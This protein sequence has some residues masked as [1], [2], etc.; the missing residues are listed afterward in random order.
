MY[1]DI[2]TS[3][4]RW[5]GFSVWRLAMVPAA[6]ALLLG[7][8]AVGLAGPINDSVDC[9]ETACWV[10]MAVRCTTQRVALPRLILSWVASQRE[11]Y[12]RQHRVMD[13]LQDGPFELSAER[14]LPDGVPEWQGWMIPREDR[15]CVSGVFYVGVPVRGQGLS[16]LEAFPFVETLCIL[17]RRTRKDGSTYWPRFCGFDI[18]RENPAVTIPPFE[19]YVGPIERKDV[20]YVENLRCL[21][22]VRLIGVHWGDIE[23]VRLCNGASRSLEMLVLVNTDVTEKG[24]AGLAP[25]RKLDRLDIEDMEEGNGP[26]CASLEGLPPLPSLQQVCLNGPG[27]PGKALERLAACTN[28]RYLNLAGARRIRDD[29]LKALARLPHLESLDL[30]GTSVTAAGLRFLATLPSLDRITLGP[31]VWGGRAPWR[32]NG[33][34]S[35]GFGPSGG[36]Q[37]FSKVEEQPGPRGREK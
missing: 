24:L 19:K 21:K 17:D 10:S 9:A 1:C 25:L 34:Q 32:P 16:T 27:I 26:S 8:P 30:E 22:F 36:G 12:L 13:E 3:W 4:T 14:G 18:T 35:N 31:N 11:C 7:R 15:L 6:F 2:N 23:L 20:S 5:S 28:I 29:D 37:G 33:S